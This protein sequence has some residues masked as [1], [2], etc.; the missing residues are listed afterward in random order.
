MDAPLLC[1]AN[2]LL[3]KY[4]N[5]AIPNVAKLCSS[6]NQQAKNSEPKLSRNITANLKALREIIVKRI[7]GKLGLH[8]M[9]FE[10]SALRECD[11]GV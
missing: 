3:Q 11:F 4:V 7:F 2:D 10:M 6:N 9:E 8:C 5:V 1:N